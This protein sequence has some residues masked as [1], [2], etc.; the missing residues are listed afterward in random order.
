MTMKIGLLAMSGI[1]AHDP[2]LLEMGLTL[3]GFVERSKTVASLPSL[4][5]L[6][7]AA[8]TPAGHRVR[9]YEA[10]RDGAEPAEVYAC[11]LVAIGTFSA[12]VFEAYA[13]ADRLRAA[14]V[15]VALGG[16]HVSALPDEAAQHADYVIVGEGE[17]VWPVVVAEAERSGFVRSG[18]ARIFRARDYPPVDVK[19]LPVPRF[20]LLDDR[21]Y[22]R[23]TVQTSRGCPWR[24]DFCAST[25]MLSERYRKRPVEHVVRDIRA[26]MRLRE[27]PFI[28]FADD[29]TF[30]DKEWGKELCRQLIPLGIR[31]FTETDISVAEDQE[32]QELMRDAGCRQ[33]LIGLESP[34]PVGLGGIE[35][36]ADMKAQWVD[37]YAERIESIQSHGVTVN[38]CFILGLDGHT[39]DV[40]RQVLDFSI[41]HRLYDVQ[42]TVLT[43]FPGT[44]LYARL[45]SENRLIE[46]RRWDLCTLF[47]VNYLPSDMTPQ[48]LREGMYWLSERLYS[49]ETTERRRKGF[50]RGVRRRGGRLGAHVTDRA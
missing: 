46:D 14:G 23:F 11:D 30:V 42:I 47:D 40:F 50:F 28:E 48:Q 41:E 21:P 24:C 6:Y 5:L 29:N 37:R 45:K 34:G 27:R 49:A 38:G 22:N 25:V 32:L 7:L 17:N 33:V 13:V 36:R 3:P 1:R 15:K 10:E 35:T 12:Q 19:Q 20:D 44:P 8:V 43:A 16:L 31:W 18:S 39:T 2:R 9:Y 4:G 26:I